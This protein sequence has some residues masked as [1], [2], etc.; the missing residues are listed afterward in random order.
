MHDT[1]AAFAAARDALAEISEDLHAKLLSLASNN[2]A[3]DLDALEAFWKRVAGGDET[4][5]SALPRTCDTL[6]SSCSAYAI[7][8]ERTRN[9]IGDIVEETSLELAAA[10][11]IVLVASLL[12]TPLG[13]STIGGGAGTA[14]LEAAGARMAVVIGQAVV[15]IGGA[16]GVV[17]AAEAAG[18]LTAAINSTP[19]PSVSHG[20][21]TSVGNS[22]GTGQ[23]NHPELKTERGQLEKKYKH[24]PDFGVTE[25]RGAEGFKKFDESLQDF[26]K[27]PAT[28]SKVGTYHGQPAILHFDRQ[29]GQAIVQKPSGEFWTGWR[30][31]PDQ[32]NNVITR[33]K[34][35]GG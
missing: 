25:S 12:T 28:E 19:D 31:S 29:T 16:V 8:V 15:A 23:S 34:L 27:S 21:S 11:G 5:L 6:G 2:I 17:A 33:G 4:L 1:A 13:G 24:A 3:E 18:A 22:T 20:E 14:V 30:L 35:G 7:E 26:T 10:T 32:L 9:D